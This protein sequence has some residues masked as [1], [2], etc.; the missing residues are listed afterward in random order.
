MTTTSDDI[1]EAAKIQDIIN[2]DEQ[3]K[4]EREHQR[5]VHGQQ[6][7]SL[8]VDTQKQYYKWNS[9]G[10]GGDVFTW[11]K[12]HRG[13]EFKE[14]ML[15]LAKR[16]GLELPKFNEAEQKAIEAR[17]A[18]E[19]VFTAAARF[20]YQELSASSEALEYVKGRGWNVEGT[21]ETPA[22]IKTSGLGYWTGNIAKLRAF[23]VEQQID[24]ECPAAVALIGLRGGV[25]EWARKWNITPRAEWLREDEIRGTP[26]HMLI[27]PHTKMGRVGYFSGR[28]IGEK[29]HY[30]LPVELAGDK[31][32]FF[33]QSWKPQAGRVVLVEGQAD[34]VTL[35]QWGVAAI[36][37]C[38]AYLDERLLALINKHEQIFVGLDNDRAGENNRD[39]ILDQL[40]PMARTVEWPEKDA[41]EWLKFGGTTETCAQLLKNAPTWLD[42]VLDRCHD[43]A[44]N[45]VRDDETRHVF[46]LLI[47]LDAFVLMRRRTEI[48]KALNLSSDTFDALLKQARREAGLDD[49]GRAQY[50]VTANRIF[51]RVYDAYG[52]D[53]MVCLAHF[54]AQIVTDVVE[55]DGENQVRKFEVEGK[56]PSGKK[57]PRVEVEAGEF[58]QM[59]WPLVKWGTQAVMSAGSATKDHLRVALLTLSKEIE[60]RSDYSHTGWRSIDGEWRYLSATGA[61]GV[62]GVRVRLD[63]N[64]RRYALP[65]TPENVKEAVQASLR[66]L[67]VADYDISMP[68]LAAVFL[69]PLAQWVPMFF[70]LWLFGTTGSLKSTLTALAMCHFGKFSFNTPPASWTATQNALE[71]LAFTLKDMVLWIDDFTSQSTVSG[72]QDL[73]RKADQLLRDWGNGSGR[74]RMRSDLSLRQTFVP[75]G[76]IISTAEQLPPIESINSRLFQIESGPDRVTRGEGSPL[77][78]AQQDDAPLYAHT[79]AGYVL[80]IAGQIDDLAKRLPLLQSELTERARQDGGSHLRLPANLATLYIGFKMFMDFAVSVGAMVEEDALALGSVAWNVFIGLGGRQ[81]EVALE[82]KPVEM[83]FGALEQMFAQGIAFLRHKDAAEIDERAWPS[84]AVRTVNCEFLGWYD[85]RYWYLLPRVAFNSVYGFYK[86]S[87][88][89]FPDTERGVRVKMLERKLL[90]P[91]KDRFTS[92]LRVGQSTV[93]VLMV[94]RPDRDESL[95]LSSEPVTTVTTVTTVTES[96][97]N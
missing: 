9:K 61:V 93:R 57:L 4:A 56:L 28:N 2:E 16:Y 34:A 66:F 18:R 69:A 12:L 30:N 17:R 95:A 72:Q 53:R 11:L 39:K 23:L 83:Y 87:G 35:G 92:V 20:F 60:M 77:T 33:N 82:E 41:N 63:H 37:L 6:H 55:D 79:M 49:H 27:Y 86:R 96:E 31:Q 47:K 3:L 94:A 46:T 97:E 21:D 71:K 10:E 25:A 22:T 75:R 58:G 90:Y 44:D 91:N 5:Y 14:A 13:M 29:R 54:A 64:L 45:D 70:T 42:V 7:D 40:G 24:P 1:K 52:H 8:V 80:W 51:M 50:E 85:D 81:Q 38:G 36:G 59:A 68:L 74:T 26:G 76:L 88:T 43:A 73:L 89:V 67:E 15:Y 48:A 62:D 65:T 32:V 78:T 84:A 19:D